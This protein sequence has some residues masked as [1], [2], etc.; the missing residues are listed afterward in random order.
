MVKCFYPRHPPFEASNKTQKQSSRL[1]VAGPAVV[2][3]ARGLAWI[4]YSSGASRSKGKGTGR[5]VDDSV[6]PEA[7]DPIDSVDEA[8]GSTDSIDYAVVNAPPTPP[9]PSTPYVV[10]QDPAAEPVAKKMAPVA[11]TEIART[12][13][14][15]DLALD[16]AAE[17]P[18]STEPLATDP[19]S[20]VV[21][22]SLEKVDPE[23]DGA[24]PI[25]RA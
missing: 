13:A 21:Y 7:I 18:Y 23:V 14:L 12:G 22:P 10:V 1:P 19:P 20:P 16:P 5:K 2:D 11:P 6:D 3:P 15:V 8:N 4:S 25:A 24:K 9:Y 17:P